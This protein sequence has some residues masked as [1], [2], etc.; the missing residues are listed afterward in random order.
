MHP[1]M[2]DIVTT[3]REPLPLTL[4]FVAHHLDRGVER[5]HLYFD[6]PHDPAIDLLTTERQVRIT[7]CD[8]HYWATNGGR[9]AMIMAR[10][11]LNAAVALTH[12]AAPWVLHCDADE[13][14]INPSFVMR[15]LAALPSDIDVLRLSVWERCVIEGDAGIGLFGGSC[16]KPVMD[17]VAVYGA[18]TAALL[19]RGMAAYA[20]CKSVTR[21]AA[22]LTIGIHDSHRGLR[23]SRAERLSPVRRKTLHLPQIIHFDGLTPRHAATKLADRGREIPTARRGEI[24]SAA[25]HAQI[26]T[27]SDPATDPSRHF[28]ALRSVSP[29]A[30]KALCQREALMPMPPSVDPATAAIRRWRQSKPL[31]EPHIFDRLVETLP[32]PQGRRSA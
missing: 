20:G 32:V 26:D 9:P 1:A 6:D 13:F 23:G 5:L 28:M 10:Q 11:A 27:L 25:R 8:A 14:L 21:V 17:P 18:Q 30:A 24:L 19:T 29:A 7:V 31:F 2:M 22:G 4:A 15:Q 3:L 12:V 16:R